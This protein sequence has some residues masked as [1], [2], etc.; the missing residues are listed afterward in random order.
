MKW[1]S[2]TCAVLLALALLPGGAPLAP[3]Q[4]AAQPTV[5]SRVAVYK[6]YYRVIKTG[7]KY[8][9]GYTTSYTDA[10]RTVHNLNEDPTIHAWWEV[11]YRR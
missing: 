10:N 3:D 11:Q 6:I 4:A 8:Y 1:F 5:A 9:Y 2:L 7:K